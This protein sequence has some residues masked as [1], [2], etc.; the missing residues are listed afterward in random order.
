M[1]TSRPRW[2]AGAA[3]R[4][5]Q[6]RATGPG[7]SSSKINRAESAGDF[8]SLRRDRGRSQAPPAIPARRRRNA[9]QVVAIIG[10][11][12]RRQVDP[13]QQLT[14]AG[15]RRGQALCHARPDHP[16]RD[17]ARR[18]DRAVYDTVGF[19][20]EAA[21]HAGRPRFAPHSKRSARPRAPARDRRHATSMRASRPASS[22]T[23]TLAE[24]RAS[25]DK[26]VSARAQQVDRLERGRP[27]G[28][29]DHFPT[30]SRSRPRGTTCRAAATRSSACSTR[31]CSALEVRVP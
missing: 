8:R 9:V 23:S 20:P 11:T 31:A 12:R 17:P 10:Y 25:G 14:Q 7:R 22:R 3:G 15:S 13:A 28:N 18:Q 6:R 19:H 21:R 4:G 16:A 1:D 26:A 30:R 27:R 2:A 5:G 29:P 24:L